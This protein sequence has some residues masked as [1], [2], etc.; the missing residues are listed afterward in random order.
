[1]NSKI[2]FRP[3]A[4]T[5]PGMYKN[6]YMGRRGGLPKVFMIFL[7]LEAIL[8]RIFTPDAH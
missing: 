2:T 5:R 4:A 7:K 6:V 3:N 1:M 8:E